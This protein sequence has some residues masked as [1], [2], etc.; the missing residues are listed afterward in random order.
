MAQDQLRFTN[1]LKR[2]KMN[3]NYKQVKRFL[4]NNNMQ[5]KG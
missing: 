5:V 3:K 1:T 2:L 4:L